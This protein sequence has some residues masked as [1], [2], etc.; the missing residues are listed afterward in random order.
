M[1]THSSILAWRDAMDRGPWWAIVH[2]VTKSLTRPSTH[3]H[4]DQLR[5][6]RVSSK[7]GGGPYFLTWACP[8]HM[9]TT[10]SFLPGNLDLHG[11]TSQG[12]EM[13]LMSFQ[14]V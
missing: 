14:D 9:C 6:E 10:C 4:T 13:T 5:P 1:A 12:P 11:I 8:V 3:A 2:G 7:H